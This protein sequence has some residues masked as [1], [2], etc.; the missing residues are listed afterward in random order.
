MNNLN[1]YDVL[2]NSYS[3][4]KKQMGSLKNMDMIMIQNYQIIT[5]KY[6]IIQIKKI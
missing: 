1:L 4:K 6:I 2:K 5:N 3:D